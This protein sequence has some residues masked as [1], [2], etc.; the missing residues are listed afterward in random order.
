VVARADGYAFSRGQTAAGLKESFGVI[1]GELF[2]VLQP[3]ANDPD[4]YYR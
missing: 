2:D 3:G 1:E 4:R